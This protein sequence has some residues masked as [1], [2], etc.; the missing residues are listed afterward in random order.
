MTHD[1]NESRAIAFLLLEDVCQLSRTDVMMGRGD[2]LSDFQK[3]TLEQMASRI[4][5]GEP[6]QYVIGKA[7]FMG[8]PI[9]VA[10]GVLIPRPETEEL[11]EYVLTH[12]ASTAESFTDTSALTD[13]SVLKILDI[14]TGSGCIA[15]SLKHHLPNA[16]I[17][18]IDI[19]DAALQQA[20]A[21]AD[22]LGLSITFHK[23][24]I[25]DTRQVSETFGGSDGQFSAIVSNPPYIC[26]SERTDM[27]TNVL[28]HEPSLALFVPDD[29]PLLFYRAIGNI[30]LP[31]L[32]KEGILAFEINRR[33]GAEVCTLLESL[34]YHAVELHLDIFG[35]QRIV[36][37]RR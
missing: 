4:A 20:S 34:G 22:D 25:L 8:L 17:H 35:N 18:A 7:E 33:Y 28:D 24:D 15:L 11:V 23:C 21:N 36:T 2:E 37:A 14:G 30:A 19:S 26:D 16:E 1:E 29:D 32:R 9:S 5:D 12:I 10:S 3:S 27:E 6:V 13:T 31:L